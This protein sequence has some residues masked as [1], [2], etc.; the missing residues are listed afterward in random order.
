MNIL[1]DISVW[2]DHLRTGNRVLLQVL[3]AARVIT[4]EGIIGELA[5]GNLTRRDSFLH[6]L[7]GLPLAVPASHREV[8]L[9][10]S[11]NRL[12]GRGVGHP[13]VHLLAS[14]RLTSDARLWT[15]D[16]RPA[17]VAEE[18]DIAFRP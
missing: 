3:M 2:I 6:S 10:I 5:L 12:Q 7:Q 8:M 4:H 13:D 15:H 16:K 17:A 1:V 11:A 18:L 9:L 14:A